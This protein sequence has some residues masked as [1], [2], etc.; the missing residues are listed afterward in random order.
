M[1][2]KEL[3]PLWEIKNHLEAGGDAPSEASPGRD[4]GP[5]LLQVHTILQA[6]DLLDAILL[7]QTR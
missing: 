6:L 5:Q 1:L 7:R 4:L 3:T 2:F